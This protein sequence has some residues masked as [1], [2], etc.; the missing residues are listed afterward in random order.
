MAQTRPGDWKNYDDFAAGIAT[1][2]LP[3]SDALV[4]QSLRIRL[5]QATLDLSPLS[6]HET[7]WTEEGGRA[8]GG[9]DGYEAIEIA[10]D[11]FFVD[12]TFASR[13]DEALTLVLNRRTRRALAIRCH[14][15]TA[16]EAGSE[17]RVA[18]EFLPGT[19]G[20]DP[21][22]ATGE[23]PAE[24]RDLI[25][26]RTFQT[27][28]PNHTYEH[29]YLNSQRYAWQCLVGVQRGHGDVDLASTWRFDEGLYV[30]TFREFLI[31][32]ASVFLFD[33]RTMRSTGKFVGL[34]GDGA[35]ANSP[36][37]AYITK[38]S[39]TFYPQGAEPV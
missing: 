25:G 7:R 8:G 36:A 13:P 31:P 19:I 28:S 39:M 34:T 37:G 12:L 11:T 30:F 3:G 26:L 16:E 35:I 29:T 21:A 4:G 2:R 27:Y 20:D 5:P 17:P 38:A 24:T 6:R 23:P 18:Q 22:T 1:N 9:V 10:A 33:F 32:V 15:R 14:I